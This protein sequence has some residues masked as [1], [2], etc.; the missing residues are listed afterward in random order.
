M[1]ILLYTYLMTEMLAP[2]F[3]SLLII[4][5]VLILGRLMQVLD[6]IFGFGIGVADFIRICIYIMPGL[7]LFSL[8]MAGMIGIILA[9]TK[10]TNDNEIMSLKAAGVGI[11]RMLP[12]VLL[13][14]LIAAGLT[15][16]ASTY[17][18]PSGTVAMKKMLFQLAKEKVE[19]GLQEKK[20]SEGIGDVV[21][22]VDT[23]SPETK[24]WKGVY[25]SD[26]RDK[27]T[28]LTILAKSGNLSSQVEEMNL[29]LNLVDGSLHRSFDDTSQTIQFERYTLN[30]PIE[31]PTNVAGQAATDIGKRGMTLNQLM[32][33]MNIGQKN[34][35]RPLG[36]SQYAIEFHK[37]LVLPVGCFILSVIGLPLALLRTTP[38]S[39]PLG[40]PLGIGTFLFYYILTTAGKT[41]AENG[42]M[43]VTIAMWTPNIICA[44]LASYLVYAVAREFQGRV[45]GFL[46]L[47]FN[48]CTRLFPF[49]KSE[50]KK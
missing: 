33:K 46:I 47:F 23:I 41:F 10:M 25:L 39:K 29:I 4:N 1:P 16:L 20:F 48:A 15:G 22:Y 2:F 11:Y 12:P 19:K 17:L 43:P 42:T 45:A 24:E 44:V 3:A 31:Q 26:L 14:A 37:R 32:D 6:T 8:P 28:P 18:I 38:R 34:G 40:L 50:M 27:K 35:E 13:F 9:F 21:L 49:W 30:L 7:L 5:L 36:W